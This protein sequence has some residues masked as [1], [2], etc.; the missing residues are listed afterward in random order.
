[1]PSTG[2]RASLVNMDSVLNG[3]SEPCALRIFVHN[4]CRGTSTA[5]QLNKTWCQY[6]VGENRSRRGG[7]DLCTAKIAL[8]VAEPVIAVVVVVYCWLRSTWRRLAITQTA[9]IVCLT[10]C[11]MD[12]LITIKMIII[13]DYFVHSFSAIVRFSPVS[14]SIGCISIAVGTTNTENFSITSVGTIRWNNSKFFY[15]I[16]SAQTLG[17]KNFV[18]IL[19]VAAKIGTLDEIISF[20]TADEIGELRKWIRRIT[21]DQ[22]DPVMMAGSC[23]KFCFHFFEPPSSDM[24][25][26]TFA[27]VFS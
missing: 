18:R 26:A 2:T 16:V 6:Y 10:N 22:L 23:M 3:H 25:L 20:C 12:D 21:F 17:G 15:R 5:K 4:Q 13:G 8:P 27:S 11:I 19:P 24:V 7:N 1:M 14:W 9:L